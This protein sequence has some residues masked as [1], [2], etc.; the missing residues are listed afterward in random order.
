MTSKKVCEKG[1]IALTKAVI[2]DSTYSVSTSCCCQKVC[3]SIVSVFS[4]D[5]LAI[6]G[7]CR[8]NDF[9]LA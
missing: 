9:K 3:D 2:F 6:A 5:A 8:G 4:W 1:D 7:C